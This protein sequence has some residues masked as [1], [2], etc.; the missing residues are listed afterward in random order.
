[1]LRYQPRSRANLS[2]ARLKTY[3]SDTFT[4][5]PYTAFELFRRSTRLHHLSVIGVIPDNRL[6]FPG[7]PVSC[8][9]TQD[10]HVTRVVPPRGSGWISFLKESKESHESHSPV[11]RSV[12]VCGVLV[13][14]YIQ[15][16]ASCTAT[17]TRL[18]RRLRVRHQSVQVEGAL[19]NY[20]SGPEAVFKQRHR[21]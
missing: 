5:T 7:S 4:P 10:L 17:T 8:A 3:V 16:R 9:R 18:C 21:H 20:F 1:Q 6:L 2:N 12:C 15:H 19:P 14:R 11:L 13:H